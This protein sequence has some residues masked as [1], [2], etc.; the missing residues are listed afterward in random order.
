VKNVLLPPRA[1]PA[2]LIAALL[3]AGGAAPAL[4]QASQPAT[5]APPAAA[6]PAQ[7]GT[8]PPSHH[9]S[10]S[11]HHRAARH[12]NESVQSMIER[13]IAD[14]HT[15]LHITAAQQQTWD[16]FAQVMRDNAKDIDQAY[17]QRAEKLGSMTAVEQLQSYARIEQVKAEDVQKLLP[18]FQSLYAALSDQQKQQADQLFRDYGRRMKHAQG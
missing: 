4:A 16:Q 18:A 7:P 15:R 3:C 1:T 11:H 10:S 14:L 5:E 12:K 6:Q 17:K 8:T 13:R 9:T 2:L